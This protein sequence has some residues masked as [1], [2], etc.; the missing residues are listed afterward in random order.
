MVD[1]R[2]TTP[3]RI[4]AARALVAIA[5]LVQVDRHL[6]HLLHYEEREAVGVHVDGHHEVADRVPVHGDCAR[7]P[8][9][10][11]ERLFLVVCPI[12]APLRSSICGVDC[13]FAPVL[14]HEVRLI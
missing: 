4:E 7:A 12:R 13:P 11:P 8:L 14:A 2:R 1:K 3:E 10:E 5:D 6:G 9:A